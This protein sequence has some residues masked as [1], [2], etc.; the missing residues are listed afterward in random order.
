MAVGGAVLECGTS[1][2]WLFAAPKAKLWAVGY[3]GPAAPLSLTVPAGKVEVESMGTGMLVWE[4]GQVRIDALNLE[5]KPTI[6]SR[7]G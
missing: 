2:A 7:A 3:V 5:G 1:P 6:I 4:D